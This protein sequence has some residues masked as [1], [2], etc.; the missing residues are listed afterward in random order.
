MA[1]NDYDCEFY[2]YPGKANK[3]TDAL[4]LKAIT[5][6][7][8]V[9]KMSVQLWSDMYNLEMEVIVGKLSALT[10]QWA[11]MEAIKG[12][13]LVDSQMKKLKHEVLENK[14]LNFYISDVGVL[15]YKDGR[16]CVPNDE[17]IKR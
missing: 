12:G 16:I 1:G 10:I 4:S 3:V 13:Q 2:Y 6:A 17:K 5:F 14:R 15:G 9:E 11:I 7:I 8:M